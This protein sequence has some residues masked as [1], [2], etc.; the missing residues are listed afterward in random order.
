MNRSRFGR[1][2]GRSPGYFTLRSFLERKGKPKVRVSIGTIETNGTGCE[3][4]Y[5]D[6]E[7]MLASC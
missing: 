5:S 3:T 7:K 1:V 4:G 2:I 6:Q